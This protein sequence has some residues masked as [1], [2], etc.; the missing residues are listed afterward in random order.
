MRVYCG[1]YE[2]AVRC[3]SA[4]IRW[5]ADYAEPGAPQ[6][7]K[8]LLIKGAGFMVRWRQ[9]IPQTSQAHVIAAADRQRTNMTYDRARMDIVECN[10]NAAVEKLR[11]LLAPGSR[12]P[13]V[14]RCSVLYLLAEA[15]Q[16]LHDFAG[17]YQHSKEALNAANLAGDRAS[18]LL[19]NVQLNGIAL[20]IDHPASQ[21]Y[22]DEALRLLPAAQESTKLVF[23]AWQ[24]VHQVQMA[25]ESRSEVVTAEAGFRQQTLALPLAPANGDPPS[26]S[27]FYTHSMW[28]Q[29]LLALARHHPAQFVSSLNSCRADVAAKMCI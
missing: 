19:L 5:R 3:C 17:A 13:A 16:H 11:P 28:C 4:M 22:L 6:Q 26:H 25:S 27:T 18:I 23:D 12:L 8:L 21:G 2:Q 20:R 15:L 10:W 7:I 1:M 9:T 29:S 14:D 24:M